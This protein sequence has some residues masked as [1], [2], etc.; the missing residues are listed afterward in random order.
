MT[1]FRTGAAVGMSHAL[2]LLFVTALVALPASAQSTGD[3]VMVKATT[4]GCHD[5]NVTRQLVYSRRQ[6][7]AAE[8]KRLYRTVR[9]G[10]CRILKNDEPAIVDEIES[11][12][13][14]TCVHMS[15]DDRNRGCYWVFNESLR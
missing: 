14:F 4:V 2:T 15:G 8:Q 1:T 12:G 10:S 5:S 11:F 13:T 9:A 3:Q 7:S 6:D